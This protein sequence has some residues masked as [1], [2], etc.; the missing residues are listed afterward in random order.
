VL[1]PQCNSRH[2]YTRL[3]LLTVFLVYIVVVIPI[4][5]IN[6]MTTYGID[7]DR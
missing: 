7:I 5:Y 2:C 1:V 3:I 6:D 4:R